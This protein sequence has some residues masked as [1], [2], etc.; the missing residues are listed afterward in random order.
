VVDGNL[1]LDAGGDGKSNACLDAA[2]GEVIWQ[3]GDGEAGY[4]TPYLI[5]REGKK[6]LV[7]FK[8][9]GLE[10]RAAEDGKL[11][12]RY[13]MET[14]DYCN[15]ATP[16]QWHDTFFVSHTG[17]EGSRALQWNGDALS[18]RWHDRGLGLL[19]HSGVR[20]QDRLLA[21]NDGLRG[22]NELRLIDLAT[23][24][25]VW[26]DTTVE[27]GTALVADDGHALLLTN[28]GELLLA[29]IREDR[30]DVLQ[31]VQVLPAKC[32]SQPALAHGRLICK[33]NDGGVV[34]LDLR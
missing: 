18:E 33:N 27:R 30:L 26:T 13:P 12:A 21:F 3:T 8:G 31:R 2:S 14:R 15:C 6:V 25:T 1:Y 9:Q 16:V 4:A 28:K 19:F 10:L 17:G 29:K 32:W 20:V 5:E 7:T 24:K 34:C 22:A 23:G 11:L